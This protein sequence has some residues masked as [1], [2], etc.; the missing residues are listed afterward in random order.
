MNWTYIY[1]LECELYSTRVWHFYQ[2]WLIPNTRENKKRFIRLWCLVWNVTPKRNLDWL[3]GMCQN[4]DNVNVFT[5]HCQRI[6]RHKNTATPMITVENNG[7]KRFLLQS[8]HQLTNQKSCWQ[9]QKQ[10]TITETKTASSAK[11]KSNP[12][13]VQRQ[14]LKRSLRRKSTSEVLCMVIHFSEYYQNVCGFTPINMNSLVPS[15][16]M[17]IWSSQ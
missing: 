5:F 7:E 2:T 17:T 9:E 15:L 12:F 1:C 8:Q 6:F 4:F 16:L 14:S 13:S 11:S 3:T 10:T